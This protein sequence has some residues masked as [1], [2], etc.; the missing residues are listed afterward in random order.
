MKCPVRLLCCVSEE[1]RRHNI[2]QS[3]GH[4]E[5]AGTGRL[6]IVGGGPSLRAAAHSIP[7]VDIWAINGAARYCVGLGLKRVSIYSV[8]PEPLLAELCDPSIESAVFAAHCDPSAYEAMKG[9]KVSRVDAFEAPGPTTA[10]AATVVAIRCGYEGI[11]FYGC[12]SSYEETTHAYDWQDNLSGL[13]KVR[14]GEKEYLTKPELLSQAEQLA[15]VIQA[16][17]KIYSDKSSGLLGALIAND[18]DYE[19]IAVSRNMLKKAAA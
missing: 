13:M 14:V 11:D 8:D 9:R 7:D 12:E 19:V 2:E 15:S 5:P 17:P 18:L 3:A 1:I 10:V 16:F 4:P 6:A